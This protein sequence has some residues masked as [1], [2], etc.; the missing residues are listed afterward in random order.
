MKD[1]LVVLDYEG[2]GKT[3]EEQIIGDVASEGVYNYK[4]VEYRSKVV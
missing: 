4:N 2:S 3:P 1:E